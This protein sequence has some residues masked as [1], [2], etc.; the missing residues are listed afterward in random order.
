[1]MMTTYCIC[2]GLSLSPYFIL[3]N[4]YMLYNKPG[5]TSAFPAVYCFLCTVFS[6]C[7]PIYMGPDPTPS[8]HAIHYRPHTISRAQWLERCLYL[9][10]WISALSG[11]VAVNVTDGAL[12][13]YVKSCMLMRSI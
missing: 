8:I 6:L 5:F 1:M 4:P 9:D 3:F 7:L 12:F 13:S 11:L 10:G 2:T